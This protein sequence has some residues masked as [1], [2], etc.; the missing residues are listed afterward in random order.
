MIVTI[1]GDPGAGKSTIAKAIA[2]KYGLKRYSAGDLMRQIAQEKGISLMELM[3]LAEKDASIDRAV[4]KKTIML[5]KKEDNFILDSRI[6]FHFI[7]ESIK[8]FVKV[9]PD[10]SAERVLADICKGGRTG[11]K[12][13]KTLQQVKKSLIARQK[14]ES[15]RY[16]KY[17]GINNLAVT[18]YDL[19]IDT[20]DLSMDEEIAQTL[21]WF[22]KNVKN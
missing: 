19:I 14:S 7:P 5:G 12:E 21:A 11:E 6:G 22:K 20:S 2:E 10:K 13:N 9:D 15:L 18:N 4:D 8:V 17:Y 1:A 3:N 16:K